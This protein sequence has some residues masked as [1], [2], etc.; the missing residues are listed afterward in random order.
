MALPSKMVHSLRVLARLV[1]YPDQAVRDLLPELQAALRAEAALGAARLRE[2]DALI[3]HLLSADPLKVEA[4]F[5]EQ[6]DRGRRT[7]LYLFEH[8]HGDSRDRGQAMVDL[9]KTYEEAGLMMDPGELPDHLPVVLEYAS[10]QPPEAARAFLGE[11][12][13]ILKAI[14]TALVE[15]RSPY[16]SV[17]AAVLDLAGEATE[18]VALAPEPAMDEAWQEPEPFGGCNSKGQT[19]PQPIQIHRRKAGE[20]ARA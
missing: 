14:H 18:A 13:H 10:T 12:S 3:D 11:L 1:R 2:I 4:E 5:V 6:F 8:V 9:I 19:G 17:L 16:A 20:G 15:R 7:A